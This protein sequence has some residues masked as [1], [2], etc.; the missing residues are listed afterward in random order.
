MSD[1]ERGLWRAVAEGTRDRARAGGR[2]TRTWARGI[3]PAPTLLR[4]TVLLTVFIAAEIAVPVEWAASGAYIAVAAMCALAAALLPGGAAPLTAIAVVLAAWV[5][6]G[7]LAGTDPSLWTAT[8]LAC[9]L[10]TAHAAA[11]ITQR[12]RTTTA[13]D[14][15]I[16]LTWARHV[17]LV[18][19]STVGIALTLALF[20][21]YFTGL[22]AGLAIGAGIVAAVAVI[23]V[24]ARSLHKQP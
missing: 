16:I 21:A 12:F 9:L 6:S 11:A 15:E 14:G 23:Y 20:T 18:L 7:L 1:T 10:Y 13:M 22:T 17:G 24:L 19:A 8:A 5:I 2:R 3:A 4:V